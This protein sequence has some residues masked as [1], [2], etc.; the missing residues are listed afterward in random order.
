MTIL[1][2]ALSILWII[3]LDSVAKEIHKYL[4]SIRGQNEHLLDKETEVF[5]Y[6]S[7][8]FSY[9]FDSGQVQGK[10]NLF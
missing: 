4:A 7:L 8:V 10:L 6:Y 3:L 1:D 9:S 2:R 5:F